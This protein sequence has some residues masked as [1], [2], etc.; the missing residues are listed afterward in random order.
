MSLDEGVSIVTSG[1][2]PGGQYLLTFSNQKM[3]QIWDLEPLLAGDSSEQTTSKPVASHST[4]ADP[5]TCNFQARERG[6][7]E[8][9]VAGPVESPMRWPSLGVYGDVTLVI[10][11]SDET[12]FL[13]VVLLDYRQQAIYV[14]DSGILYH[15]ETSFEA[16]IHEYDLIIYTPTP[17]NVIFHIWFD[18]LGLLNS[19]IAT[20][21]STI[22]T[23]HV[24]PDS[25]KVWRFENRC[26]FP[27]CESW[28]P[29][30]P[31]NTPSP[32]TRGLIPSHLTADW[33][34]DNSNFDPE[35]PTSSTSML[36]PFVAPYWLEPASV[37]ELMREE[38]PLPAAYRTALPL[39]T[40]SFWPFLD[41]AFP[42]MT[43]SSC[44]Q[45][46]VWVTSGGTDPDPHNEIG[47]PDVQLIHLPSAED[48]S[49]RTVAVP[50]TR[51][52]VL[53]LD[54]KKVHRIDFCDETG[55]LMV[56]CLGDLP[57]SP[58]VLHVFRY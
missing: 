40:T 5:V 27:E 30:R 1:F 10:G 39:R 52:L 35:G 57:S 4:N 14:M 22:H 47:Y 55:V 7:R 48:H 13:I 29:S 21:W 56:V 43:P 41:E 25:T 44:G 12:G 46:M 53:P 31:W 49:N 11:S 16:F 18:A 50:Y 42:L 36:C 34:V 15:E 51:R 3:A 28:Y 6:E 24:P 45:Y 33:A 58:Q 17:E 19:P 32:R 38:G 37:V 54:L 26:H 8:T 20:S 2:L 23:H 9:V